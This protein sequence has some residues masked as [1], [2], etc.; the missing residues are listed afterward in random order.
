MMD[1]VNVVRLPSE[2]MATPGVL[3][4]LTAIDDGYKDEETY[5][6]TRDQLVAIARD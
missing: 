3:D 5:G 6:P 4:K 1:V 2:V